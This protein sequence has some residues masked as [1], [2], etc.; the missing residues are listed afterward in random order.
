MSFSQTATHTTK[1]PVEA[2]LPICAILSMKSE[3]YPPQGIQGLNRG[4]R[5]E[6]FSNLDTPFNAQNLRR[7]KQRKGHCFI[8][9]PV[10]MRTIRTMV[11]CPSHH[12]FHCEWLSYEQGRFGII[13]IAQK[14]Q[15][16]LTDKTLVKAIVKISMGCYNFLS[17]HNIIIRVKIKHAQC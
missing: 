15:T 5:R 10:T 6:I 9:T 12:P 3:K 13:L 11:R 8:R 2:C 14:W 7:I 17:Y 4:F 16:N 1:A